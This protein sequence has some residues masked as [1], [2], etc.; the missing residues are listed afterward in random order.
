MDLENLANYY[1]GGI[2]SDCEA[3]TAAYMGFIEGYN[4]NRWIYTE[5]MPEYDG[6]YLCH[7]FRDNECGT[8]S[9]YQEVVQCVCNNWMVKDRERVSHWQTLKSNPELNTVV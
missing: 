2:P 9:N 7:I 4:S 8:V 3:G 5:M 6:A 1:A